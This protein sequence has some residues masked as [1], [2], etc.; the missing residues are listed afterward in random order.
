MYMELHPERY[1]KSIHDTRNA[2]L[3]YTICQWNKTILLS[4]M[5]TMA[6]F[7]ISTTAGILIISTRADILIPYS[8]TNTRSHDLA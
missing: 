1:Q 5:R 2:T 7:D 4:I 6:K 8:R 3:A